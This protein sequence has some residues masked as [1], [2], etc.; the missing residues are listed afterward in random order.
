MKMENGKNTGKKCKLKSAAP[1][2]SALTVAVM[3]TMLKPAAEASLSDGKAVAESNAKTIGVHFVV[4][5]PEAQ[6]V[7]LCGAF[8]GWSPEATPMIRQRDGY[9]EATVPLPPGRHENTSSW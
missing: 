4:L 5:E 6:R 7:S 8:N 9:W 3:S 1:L 2:P